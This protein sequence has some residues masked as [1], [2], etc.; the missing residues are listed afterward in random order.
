MQRIQINS[1]SYGTWCRRVCSFIHRLR[2]ISQQQRCSLWMVT[3]HCVC[4]I[5]SEIQ[6]CL[7]CQDGDTKANAIQVGQIKPDTYFLYHSQWPSFCPQCLLITTWSGNNR[8]LRKHCGLTF[9]MRFLK[10]LKLFALCKMK[11]IELE[12]CWSAIAAS[13]AIKSKQ[14]RSARLN[15]TVRLHKEERLKK[16][17]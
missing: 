16:K 8:R 12:W 11:K 6:Q 15:P 2:K 17:E 5:Q 1:L 7:D 14:C 13:A 4:H 9:L 10:H 3:D